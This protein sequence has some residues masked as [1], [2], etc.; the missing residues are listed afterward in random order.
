MSW[1]KPWTWADDSKSQRQQRND[2]NLQGAE[3]GAFADDAQTAF[4]NQRGAADALKAQMA[5]QAAGRN[6]I[7]AEQLRQ[8]LQQNLAAQRSMAASA[9]PRDA[10]MAARTAAIQAG[11]LGSGMSGAAAVAG[12]QE[13]AN[14]RDSLAN[15]LTQQRQQELQA[16]LGARQNAIGAFGGVKPEGSTLDKWGSAIIGGIGAGAQLSDRRAKMDIRDG[17]KESE[18]IV[19]GLKSF[20]YRYK[21]RKHG[22]G[23]QLGVMAQDLERVGLKHAVRNTPEGKA[24]DG[25]RLS[26]ANTALIASLGE[27]LSKLEKKKGGS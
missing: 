21:D 20:S 5:N 18:N 17:S 14:A 22:E 11:R 6:L 27:R 26:T 10:A 16:S 23:P 13:A 25:A 4:I 19:N 15:L 3:S 9:A 8:G 24:V 12:M 2:M 7:S 1:Y